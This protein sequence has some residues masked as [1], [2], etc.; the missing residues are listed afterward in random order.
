MPYLLCDSL[1][2]SFVASRRSSSSFVRGN[3]ELALSEGSLLILSSYVNYPLV[4]GYCLRLTLSMTLPLIDGCERN[5]LGAVIA[6]DVDET[7]NR[8][9]YHGGS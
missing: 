6:I 5:S 2:W 1:L 9:L 8:F 7:V 3:I 4:C